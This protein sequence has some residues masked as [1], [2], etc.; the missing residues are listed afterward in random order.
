MIPHATQELKCLKKDKAKTYY[1]RLFEWLCKSS[2]WKWSYAYD[3]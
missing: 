1:I 3:F 2:H